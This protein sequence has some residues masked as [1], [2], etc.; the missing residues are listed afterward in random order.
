MSML[1]Y[2]NEWPCLKTMKIVRI[3][4]GIMLF[5]GITLF[6]LISYLNYLVNLASLEQ[7]KKISETMTSQLEISKDQYASIKTI[8][9]F[10]DNYLEVQDI[11]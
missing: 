11:K 3:I 4:I 10:V 1:D 5:L 9:D 7:N 2:S 8:S 6:C